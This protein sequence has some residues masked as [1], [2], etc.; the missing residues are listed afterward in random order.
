MEHLSHLSCGAS[1]QKVLGF[2]SSKREAICNMPLVRDGPIFAVKSPTV[3]ILGSVGHTVCCDY[4]TLR[5]WRENHRRPYANEPA[6]LC[7]ET[8]FFVG[9][10]ICVSHHFHPSGNAVQIFFPPIENVTTILSLWTNCTK[11]EK[12]QIRPAP[13]LQRCCSKCR[14]WTRLSAVWDLRPLLKPAESE[15]PF[16]QGPPGNTHTG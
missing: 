1:F 10:E 8:A 3:N 14:P 15:P 5:L 2:L 12:G 16:Q 11:R 7:S 13:D 9:T 4:S 6:G